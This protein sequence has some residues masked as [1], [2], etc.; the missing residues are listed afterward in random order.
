VLHE[1]TARDVTLSTSRRSASYARRQRGTARIR[2][3]LLLS[4]GR[5]EIDQYLLPAGPTAANLYIDILCGHLL[6][7]RRSRENIGMKID[8]KIM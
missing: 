8:A 4:A 5:P 6:D 7:G 1:Y 2:P 3:A